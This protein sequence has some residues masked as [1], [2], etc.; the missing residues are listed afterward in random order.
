TLAGAIAAHLRVCSSEEQDVVEELF[1]ELF[2]A[3]HSWVPRLLR[4]PADVLTERLEDGLADVLSFGIH[5]WSAE[6]FGGAA[7]CWKPGVDSTQ[8]RARLRA[9][10]LEGSS[11]ANVHVCGEAYSDFQGFIEGSLRSANHAVESVLGAG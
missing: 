6:A 4:G 1:S 3:D 8:V 9:F 7:H 11:V 5:D 2:G 10:A